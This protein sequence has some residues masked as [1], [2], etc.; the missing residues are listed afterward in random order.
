[1]KQAAKSALAGVSLL[2]VS[3]GAYAL[4]TSTGD[5]GPVES[6]P[7]TPVH[8][9]HRADMVREHAELSLMTIC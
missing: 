3:L 2:F 7:S 5:Q 1:M 8:A 4:L 9:E 6:S